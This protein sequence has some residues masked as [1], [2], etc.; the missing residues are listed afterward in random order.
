MFVGLG[1]FGYLIYG[2]YIWYDY[3]KV[4]LFDEVVIVDIESDGIFWCFWIFVFFYVMVFLMVDIK[5]ISQDIGN[6]D[7]VCFILYWF[8]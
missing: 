4:V 5:S 6:L 3:K 7:I 2:E 8:E 1:M